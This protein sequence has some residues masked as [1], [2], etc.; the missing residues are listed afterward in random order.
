MISGFE[1]DKRVRKLIHI[2]QLE[3][4]IRKIL[5]D[6]RKIKSYGE[7]KWSNRFKRSYSHIYITI[8]EGWQTRILDFVKKGDDYVLT[9]NE[10]IKLH[11]Y[12]GIEKG[13]ISDFSSKKR[14]EKLPKSVRYV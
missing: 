13:L 8:G 4:H 11:D 9:E 10:D 7:H 12:L 3:E 14:I 5:G 6:K 2:P 1:N